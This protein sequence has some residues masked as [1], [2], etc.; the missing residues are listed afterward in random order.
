MP[1]QRS[2]ISRQISQFGKGLSSFSCRLEN[3]I[4]ELK[5]AVVSKP[6]TERKLFAGWALFT[7]R[8]ALWD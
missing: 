4:A 7:S 1:H 2:E 6:H 5:R 8:Q 3:D